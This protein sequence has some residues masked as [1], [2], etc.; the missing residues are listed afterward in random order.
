MSKRIFTKVFSGSI[1]ATGV[2]LVGMDAAET[3]L[4]QEDIAVIGSQAKC[5]SVQPSENDGFAQVRVELSQVG[6]EAQDG[7]ILSVAA[8][9]G[10]NTAPP[11]I[12]ALAGHTTVIFPQGV[13]VPVKE[14]GY[15]YI[16]ASTKGKTAG[17]S[18]FHFEVIV[19]YTKKGTK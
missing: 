2:M 18:I 6:K 13:A 9:E 7:A 5:Y 14:E 17:S 8:S 16:N 3:W 11:G 19:Y 4:V 12:A 1:T 15:L 10:W